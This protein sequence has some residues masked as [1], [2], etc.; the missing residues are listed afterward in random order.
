MNRVSFDQEVAVAKE[1]RDK[2]GL[3]RKP[4]FAIIWILLTLAGV[5]LLIWLIVDRFN[6]ERVPWSQAF[7]AI[8]S[9]GIAIVAYRQWIAARYEISIDKYYDRLDVANRRLELLYPD[10]ANHKKIMHV[11]AQLDKLEYVIIKYELGYIS[12]LL[13]RRAILDFTGHSKTPG[14]CALASRW[15]VEGSYL[16]KTQEIVLL[17]CREQNGN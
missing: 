1:L 6:L 13:A 8:L 10:D 14:F 3:R 16:S 11:F 12:P 9:L 17:I 15:V 5:S 4:T 2:Y 7:A